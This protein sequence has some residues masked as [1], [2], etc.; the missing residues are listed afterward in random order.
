MQ[1]RRTFTVMAILLAVLV[2]G[3]GYA[4]VT[5]VT[6]DLNGTANINA[7]FDFTV[8]YDT[9]HS[10]VV[11]PTGVTTLT[12]GTTTHP[13]VQGAYSSKSLATMTVWLDKDH[14]TA[15]A[16]Y[17]VDNKSTGLGAKLTTT[18]TNFT[19]TGAT[20]LSEPTAEYFTD[21]ACTDALGSDTL[22]HGQS[23]YLKVTVEL[24]KAPINDVT[25]ATFAVETTAEPIEE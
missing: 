8:E 15:Y 7:N 19:G 2:L 9:A 22:P 24:A 21:A 10:V 11:N 18:V 23:A 25:G 1:K 4:V 17:K 6:L 5:N 14:T 12:D 13:F 16:I 20:Y 3:V